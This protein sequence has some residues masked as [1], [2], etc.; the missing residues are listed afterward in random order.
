MRGYRA[1][2]PT[3]PVESP[4]L[5]DLHAHRENG[6]DAYEWHLFDELDDLRPILTP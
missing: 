6:T 1:P 3:G 2:R 5:A 4:A